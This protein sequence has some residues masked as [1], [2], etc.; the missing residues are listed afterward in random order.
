MFWLSACVQ[1]SEF[2]C[3]LE[4]VLE[5]ALEILKEPPMPTV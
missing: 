1:E 3:S 4:T 5:A 2:V